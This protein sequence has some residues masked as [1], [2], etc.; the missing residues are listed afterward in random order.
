[1]KGKYYEGTF[2]FFIILLFSLH[3]GLS[4]GVGNQNTY[5]IQGLQWYDSSLLVN[6]W[7]ASQTTHYHHYFSYLFSKI[8]EFLFHC[9]INM[10]SPKLDPNLTQFFVC[11]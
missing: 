5:L 9:D 1:M 6:D 11:C 2:L 3:F 10:I 8:L 4:Y 7:F